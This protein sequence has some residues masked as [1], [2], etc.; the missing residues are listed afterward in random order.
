MNSIKFFYQNKKYFASA[1]L[2]SCFSLIFSTWV[3]YIP[4]I[5]EKLGITEGKIGKAI[6]FSALG[7]FVMIRVCRHVVDRVG[8]GKYTFFALIV[9]CVFFFGPFLAY[10]YDTLCLSLFFFG[11]A[12]SSFAISLNSLTATIERQDEIYIMSRSHAFWSIGGMIGAATGSFIAVLLHNPIVHISILVTIILLLQ[13]KLKHYYYYRK[14]EC[15]V[16]EKH[17]K[18]NL[19]PLYVIAVVGLVMMVSE[20]AIADWS[21]LY[22]K[23]II[24]LDMKY[25]GFGYAAFSSAMM[26]GR[27]TGDSLS[28]KLGSWQLITYSSLTGIV[29]FLLVLILNPVVSILGF[30]I[31]GLGFSVVVPEVYR[32]ASK[33]EGVKTADGVSF[34][35]ATS[36]IGFL[37]GPVLLGFIAEF[38][39]LHLSFMVLTTFVSIAFFIAFVKN[40]E[41]FKLNKIIG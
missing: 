36:N 20:G 18:K 24:L 13:F 27:F 30:F 12:S 29:G 16:K 38:Q 39:S 28:K 21:A 9:Y 15:L 35:A 3:T 11:M 41:S 33:V 19:K 10:S 8:V 31:V 40:R 4:Q 6:F 22:L 26:I 2:F 1:F 34:I 37:V 25:I 23:K 5:A 17:R 14:G 7:A 32:L